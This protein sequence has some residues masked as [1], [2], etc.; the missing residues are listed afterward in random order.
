M[1]RRPAE[2]G[3]NGASQGKT[4]VVKKATC[5]ATRV[6][7]EEPHIFS[8]MSG[9]GVEDD[10]GTELGKEIAVGREP[11]MAPNDPSGVDSYL[12]L[13]VIESSIKEE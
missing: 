2:S 1:E 13:D 11:S 9:W 5:S 7:R 8:G 12:S 4:R 10:W 6:G 3:D